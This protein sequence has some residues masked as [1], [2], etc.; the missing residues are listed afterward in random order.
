[1]Y[2]NLFTIFRIP[3]RVKNLYI[4]YC[5]HGRTDGRM[6]VLFS[7]QSAKKIHIIFFFLQISLNCKCFAKKTHR[8]TQNKDVNWRCI[9]RS[10][11]LMDGQP[12]N[13]LGWAIRSGILIFQTICVKK[14]KYNLCSLILCYAWIITLCNSKQINIFLSCELCLTKH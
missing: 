11:F 8:S 13:L 10:L 4:F 6:D 2:P 9:Y 7:C 12:Y 1:M 3:L 14:Q 5:M